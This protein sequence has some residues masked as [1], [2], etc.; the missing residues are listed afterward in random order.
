MSFSPN[1]QLFGLWCRCEPKGNC[2]KICPG[3]AYTIE[4]VDPMCRNVQNVTK[5]VGYM[6]VK[7][8][9]VKNKNSVVE[10]KNLIDGTSMFFRT[11]TSDYVDIKCFD[12]DFPTPGCVCIRGAGCC[13]IKTRDSFCSEK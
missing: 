10:I 13:Q 9:F 12:K 7:S 8:S 3:C 6:D 5:E 11:G 4:A 1:C 2:R